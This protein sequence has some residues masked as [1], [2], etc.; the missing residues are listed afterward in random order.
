MQKLEKENRILSPVLCFGLIK[1]AHSTCEC[2]LNST[3]KYISKTSL[4]NE[5]QCTT[6]DTSSAF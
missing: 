4:L 1:K 3:E 6:T 2:L 5:T